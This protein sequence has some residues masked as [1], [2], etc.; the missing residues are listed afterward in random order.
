MNNLNNLS[1]QRMKS[2]NQWEVM[3]WN[4]CSS[5]IQDNVII[6]GLWF[7]IFLVTHWVCH[8][9]QLFTSLCFTFVMYKLE[10]IAVYLIQLL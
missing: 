10:I 1:Y 6:Q 4:M 9:G 8:P 2:V 3:A 5:L 7:R